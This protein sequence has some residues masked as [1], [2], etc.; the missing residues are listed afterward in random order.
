M[1]TVY[2]VVMWLFATTIVFIAADSVFDVLAGAGLEPTIHRL[3][4]LIEL[5]I[6]LVDLLM[7][8]AGGRQ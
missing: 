3:E 2:R 7:R 4:H 1:E 6:R 5:F 8:L